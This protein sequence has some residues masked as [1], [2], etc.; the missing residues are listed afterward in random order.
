MAVPTDAALWLLIAW[1]AI[2]LMA[3]VSTAWRPRHTHPA[4]ARRSCAEC[5][6][7]RIR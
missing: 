2:I 7:R 1:T 4:P 3:I 6:I 5:I